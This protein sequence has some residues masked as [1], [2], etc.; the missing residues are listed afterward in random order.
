MQSLVNRAIDQIQ[1]GQHL[2]REQMA[3]IVNFA[4]EENLDEERF[5][6][7]LLDMRT[8]GESAEEIAGA[9]DALRSRMQ[10]IQTR[11]S[12]LGDTCGTGGDASGSF[13]VSTAAA[14]V[15]AS[16]GLPVAKH[17][18][19]AVSSQS[20][21]ADVLEQLGVR[22]DLE[23]AMA[24]ECLERIGICF[25]FAPKHHPTMA[26]VAALRRR[27][28]VPTV[29]NLIGPLCNPAMATVQVIGIGRT[30]VQERLAEAASLIGLARVILVTGVDVVDEVGLSAGTLVIDVLGRVRT[31]L[32]WTPEDFGLKRASLESLRIS[33]PSESA[34]VIRQVL[35]GCEGPR[36]DIVV[37]N[38]AALLYA[39]ELTEDVAAAARL[40]E[41]AIDSGAASS[42]LRE[43]ASFTSHIGQTRG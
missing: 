13:N 33:T 14:I 5:G 27:L 38:A 22:I 34:E 31:R 29:F 16:A 26:R 41:A 23:P 10:V 35:H 19:R 43:F 1:S 8:A 36:R 6:Q 32:R 20:G 11:H 39:A 4:L 9:A 12:V 30:E 3:A 15:A 40:A 18:N 28:G 7:L 37:A 17:G 24:A 2:D 25:C 42:L 21:S